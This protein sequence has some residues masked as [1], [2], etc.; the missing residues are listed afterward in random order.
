MRRG[1]TPTLKLITEQDWTGY[2]LRLTLEE[3]SNEMTFENDRL[4]VE[5][6]VVYVALSQEETL[7]FNKS[8]QVQIKGEKDG[9]VVATD[10]VKIKVLPILNEE[11]M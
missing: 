5:A 6:S 3:G 1:T 11:A 9:I 8:V 4:T 2:D 10:I 7:S